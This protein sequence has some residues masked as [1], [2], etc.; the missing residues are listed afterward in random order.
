MRTKDFYYELDESFIGQKPYANRDQAKLMVLDKENEQIYHKSFRDLKSFLS[1]GDVL[2]LNESKVMPSRI[3]GHRPNKEEKIEVLLIKEEDGLWEAMAKPGKKLKIDTEIIFSND[4]KAK[5][6]SITPEG[7]RLLE[8]YHDKSL[9]EIL[10]NIGTMP[11]P[12]YIKETLENPSSYQ[13]VYAKNFGSAAAPTAG[14]HFTDDMIDDLVDYGVKIAKL[15]LHVGMGTFKPVFEEN[16]KDHHMHSE[17]YILDEKNAQII[18]DA[19]DNSKRVIAVG[20]TSVRTLEAIA[21][22]C[23]KIQEDLDWTDIFIY[24]GYDFKAVDAIVTNFHLPESTLLML[25]SAFYSREKILEAYEEAKKNN[26]KF[27]SFGD[28][29]FI[30]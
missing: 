25:V 21:K 17:Y 12:P 20:T 3:Y 7:I 16:I 13:T 19:K 14:L 5:V 10:A 15:S 2:V 24:P 28:A 26:Y 30:Y 23:G 27:F 11:T 4:L 6:K 8:L 9:E 22:K 1:P 18:N 29:M